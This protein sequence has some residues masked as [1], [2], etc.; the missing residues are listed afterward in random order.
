MGKKKASFEIYVNY[1]IPLT[2]LPD[3]FIYSIWTKSPAAY[4]RLTIQIC[5]DSFQWSQ[6]PDLIERHGIANMSKAILCRSH[7][8][9]HSS[10]RCLWSAG[11]SHLVKRKTESLALSIPPWKP[12][13]LSVLVHQEQ[14]PSLSSEMADTLPHLFLPV[15]STFSR[16]LKKLLPK[17]VSIPVLF[18]TLIPYD[19]LLKLPSRSQRAVTSHSEGDGA[20]GQCSCRAPGMVSALHKH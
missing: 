15:T 8:L 4:F 9:M 18:R 2:V 6:H 12:A 7:V 16:N 1:F 5:I 3:T 19:S 20:H 14:W 13:V 17:T 11:L 10:R